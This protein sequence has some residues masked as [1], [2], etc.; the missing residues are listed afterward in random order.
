MEYF[1]RRAGRTICSNV[2]YNEEEFIPT[3]MLKDCQQNQYS[4][5][6]GEVFVEPVQMY[7]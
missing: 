2:K 6:M 5:D 4:M 7:K 1:V 3:I